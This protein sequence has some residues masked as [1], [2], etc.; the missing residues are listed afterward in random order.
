M[1]HVFECYK[2]LATYTSTPV[3]LLTMAQLTYAHNQHRHLTIRLWY[4]MNT[5]RKL[6]HIKLTLQC[7]SRP[8]CTTPQVQ[9]LLCQ[10]FIVPHQELDV[11]KK[12]KVYTSK[13]E[14]AQLQEVTLPL[15]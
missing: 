15:Y 8:T 3:F 11:I 10:N 4:T 5:L 7:T 13:G 6:L 2:V 14:D 1:I 12:L 9:T